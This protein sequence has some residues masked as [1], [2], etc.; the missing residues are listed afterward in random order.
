[1]KDEEIIEK[2]KREK[3]KSP[4]V[5][6]SDPKTYMTLTEK[7]YRKTAPKMEVRDFSRN[8]KISL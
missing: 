4:P 6:L 1:M 7:L 2:F 5:N 3:D 8:R